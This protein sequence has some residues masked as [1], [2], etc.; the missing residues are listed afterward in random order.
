MHP[1]ATLLAGSFFIS[2]VLT[3][4]APSRRGLPDH[5]LCINWLRS[6]YLW[7]LCNITLIC[8]YGICFQQKCFICLFVH[9][10]LPSLHSGLCSNVDSTERPSMNTQAKQ[11]PSPFSIY[12]TT[13]L[14]LLLYRDSHYL[15]CV[16]THAHTH[17]HTHAVIYFPH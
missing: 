12:F 10:C 15:V 4:M 5:P 16:C 14:L 11:C 6:P 2:S 3:Q 9:Y 17:T 13:V 1:L 7:L 8:L